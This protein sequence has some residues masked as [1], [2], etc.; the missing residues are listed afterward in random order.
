M[1]SCGIDRATGLPLYD[2]AH[3][4]QSVG[5]IFTTRLGSIVM[6]RHFGSGLPELLGRR[7]VPQLLA[8]YRALLALSI[9]T[10]EPRLRVVRIDGAGN[11]PGAVRLGELSFRVL[12]YYRPRGHLGD[13]TIEGGVRAFT[14]RAQDNRLLF[15]LEQQKAA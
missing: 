4:E 13:P 10:W 7:V 14:L 1:A 3:V 5:L 9:N 8:A 11:A 6:R 12:A 2:L 15:A